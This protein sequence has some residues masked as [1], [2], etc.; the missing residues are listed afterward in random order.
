[1]E[2]TKEDLEARMRDVAQGVVHQGL[3]DFRPQDTV[4]LLIAQGLCHRACISDLFWPDP[5]CQKKLK[6][7]S[8]LLTSLN[9]KYDITGTYCKDLTRYFLEDLYPEKI[10]IMLMMG[11]EEVTDRQRNVKRCACLG[12]DCFYERHHN[13]EV[14]A[15]NKYKKTY[16]NMESLGWFWGS[17][18][19]R[20]AM[21]QQS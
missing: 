10:N 7:N 17:A 16:A 8:D 21:I 13:A 14:H 20:C 11:G 15:K 12:C 18:R 2:E 4:L 3:D 9:K 5:S 6:K 19:T 1:V